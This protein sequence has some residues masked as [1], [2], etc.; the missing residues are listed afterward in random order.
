MSQIDDFYSLLF[1]DGEG[2]C[3]TPDTYGTSV[4]PVNAYESH[5]GACYFSINPLL[6]S[7]DRAP[8]RPFHSAY[9]G[10]R[11]DVN[12]TSY[13]NILL[14]FD[15]LTPAE[16]LA[17]II[18]LGLPYSSIVF[19]GGKSLH[20]ILSLE[21]PLKTREDYRDIVAA[22]H[23]KVKIADISASNPS[24]LSRSPGAMRG[25]VEQEL[26]F[27]GGA[28]S[29]GEVLDFTGP[30][31][32]KP[33][34]DTQSTNKVY[35]RFTHYFLVNGDENATG[36]RN[37]RLFNASCDM[38]RCGATIEEALALLGPKSSLPT[39]EIEQCIKSAYRTVSNGI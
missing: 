29:I 18:E 36:Q 15:L 4:F 7:E 25:D 24:R 10:R 16:Q 21:E 20:V 31:P 6:L 11:A 37:R 23:R 33:P 35:N 8:S 30:L 17:Y 9:V 19:S 26:I 5:C 3:W 1:R 39:N 27:I 34:I 2:V 38:A 14:E 22:L 13:R 32:I 12:I 28:V